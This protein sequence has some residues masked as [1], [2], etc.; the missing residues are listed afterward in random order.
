MELGQRVK[1]ARLLLGLSQRQLCGDT[2]TRNM[3]SRI[4]HGT[5]RPS[6]ETLRYLAE[7]LE[8]PVSYFLDEQT[9][10]SPNTELMQRARQYYGAGDPDRVL[11]L[12]EG[13]KEPDETFD[14]ERYLLQA[15]CYLSLAEL[16][17]R[18]DRLPYAEELLERAAQA[19]KQTPYYGQ[20]LERERLLLLA[21]TGQTVK[22]AQDDRE[23]LLR[24]RQALTAGDAVRAGEYLDAAEGRTVPEW[25]LLRGEVYFALKDYQSAVTCYLAAE[26][27]YPNQV[28]PRL[29]SC[30]QALEDYKMAYH[31]VCKQR[32]Q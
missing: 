6:M 9:V 12:L 23:L 3:L 13:Y 24:S 7:K 5:V 27:Y 21:R 14:C 22:L 10:T 4:E 18:Q 17:L 11:K 1:E 19:G 2:I 20:E 29:E 31:Y 8:K 30:Y 16:A 15:K 28:W 32:E 25:Q 26:A